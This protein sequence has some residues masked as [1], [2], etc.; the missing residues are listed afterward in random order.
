MIVAPIHLSAFKEILYLSRAKKE[1][2]E[3]QIALKAKDN[4][5][6]PVHVSVALLTKNDPKTTLLIATDLTQHMEEQLKNYTSNLEKEIIERKKAE[7]KIRQ[8]NIIQNGIKRIFQ[9]ALNCSTE[10]ALGEVCLLVAEEVTGSKFGFIGEINEEGFED[11]AISNPGWDACKATTSKRHEAP[12]GSFKIHGIYGKVI[13]GA[14]GFFTNDPANFPGSVGLPVGHPLLKSFLGVPL[15]SVDKIIGLIAVANREG[16]YGEIELEAVEALAPAIAEAFLRK[17]AEEKLEEYRRNLEKLVEERTR[18][19]QVKERLATIGA[20]AGMVGHD[21]RNPLQ[22]ITGDLFL[23]R[24]EMKVMP[25]SIGRQAMQESLDSIEENIVYINKIVSDLQDFTRPLKPALETVNFK[26][27]FL[28]TVAVV[29][30]PD[31]IKTQLFTQED[32]F[33]CT[34]PAYLR[35]ALTNLIVNAVQAMQ[36]GG[37]LTIEAHPD[38]GNAV[39]RVK[40]TGVGIPEEIKPSLFT[41]LFTTKAKGQ[42][43]GLAVVKRLI[44]AMNGSIVFDSQIGKGTTFTVTLPL[45]ARKIVS[46]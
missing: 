36:D 32:F 33:F 2:V 16:G 34:D 27:L 11:I 13:T 26:Q 19:L 38:G 20:T 45:E 9:Q 4:S 43:L 25:E 37:T 35:R 17:R 24:E 10:E 5:L 18:E 46:K 44:D 22:A 6:V 8:Q 28:N 40:D 42:G 1:V 21:I 41:P 3:N 14:K 15:V 12:V 23:V 29:D 39:I 30:I 7:E 31:K